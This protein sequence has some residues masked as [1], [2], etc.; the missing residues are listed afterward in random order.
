MDSYY[1]AACRGY[2]FVVW[3][4]VRTLSQYFSHA[5][6]HL[7][8]VASVCRVDNYRNSPTIKFFSDVFPF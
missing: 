7:E 2:I 3:T 5:S 1:P 4:K 8:N 6:S